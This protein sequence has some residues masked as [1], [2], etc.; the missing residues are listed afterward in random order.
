MRNN[1]K[2]Q[3]TGDWCLIHFSY[4]FCKVSSK[5]NL[6]K[7]SFWLT[8]WVHSLLWLGAAAWAMAAGVCS[9]PLQSGSRETQAGADPL[10]FKTSAYGLEP[11]YGGQGFCPCLDPSADTLADV[12]SG[13]LP[14]LFQIWLGWQR[15]TIST[16]NSACHV[17]YGA[18]KKCHWRDLRAGKWFPW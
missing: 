13:V 5:S 14:G 6:R 11:P 4:C 8:V 15:L 17:Y 1:L 12:P 7:G 10:S 2:H 18:T 16:M 9:L 3:V